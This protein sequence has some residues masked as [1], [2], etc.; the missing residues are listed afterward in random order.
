MAGGKSVTGPFQPATHII[1]VIFRS[2]LLAGVKD[3]QFAAGQK[4]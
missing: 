1:I 3:F 2:S 4:L